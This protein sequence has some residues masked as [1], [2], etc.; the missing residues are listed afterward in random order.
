MP[1]RQRQ[2][3]RREDDG[4]AAEQD[5]EERDE[6]AEHQR[7]KGEACGRWT[8]RLRVL[9][10]LFGLLLPAALLVL[11]CEPHREAHALLPEELRP[12]RP[13][14]IRLLNAANLALAQLFGVELIPLD[15]DA[16]LDSACARLVAERG[17]GTE[18]DFGDAEY[19][20]LREGLG[21]FVRALREE[22]EL[23]LIG[24]TWATHRIAS[25]LDQRL[26]LVAYWRSEEHGAA[27]ARTQVTAPLFVVGLPRT[28]T[29]FLHTLLAQDS[30]N[31]R[32]PL[33]WMVVDPGP[34]TLFGSIDD[35]PE[36]PVDGEPEPLAA[37]RRAR[38]AEASSN[39]AQF[40]AIAPGVDAQHTMTA[41]R[42]EEC[43][44]FQVSTMLA[45][46][47]SR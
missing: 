12:F 22:A 19:G 41:S 33:N 46:V 36:S 20:S 1:P 23:T 44:V 31:F 30:E 17:A 34:P 15:A 45:D 2:R 6:D 39:L 11:F 3:R 32:S 9:S 37:V 16:M 24:R 35:D 27:V 10:V 21:V 13:L 5:N 40:K 26:R 38:I 43:I 47:F 8:A 42:P 28:G 14:A 18:C 25:L 29:S 4:A 7:A